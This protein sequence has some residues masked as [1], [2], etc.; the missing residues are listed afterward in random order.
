MSF[1]HKIVS[2]N[3][4]NQFI[5]LR[6]NTEKYLT[7]PVSIEKE[8]TRIDKNDEKITKIISYILQFI[9]SARFLASLLS[10]PVNN[11]AEWILKIKCK[12]KHNDKKFA[13]SGIKYEGCDRF[14]EYTDFKGDLIKYKCLCC[15]KNY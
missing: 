5:C 6:E 8:I 10:S 11:L 15:N 13:T 1:Y 9:E 4:L 2:K 12:R 7:S 3:I 14:I